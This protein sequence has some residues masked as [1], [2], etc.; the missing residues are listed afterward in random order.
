MA[1]TAALR[2]PLRR[3][4][5][6]F[7]HRRPWLKLSL[8]LGPPM[9]WMLLVYLGA[10]LILFLAAFWRQDPVTSVVQREWGAQNFRTLV[11]REIYRIIT[12]R[13][14]GI[15]L[16]ATLADILLALPLAYYAARL[17]TPKIRTAI[18]LSITLPLW[19]SYL[20]RVYAWRVILAD[21]GA[22]D[23]TLSKLQ[24]GALH[25]GFS[26]WSVWIVFV[27]LWL[28]YVMLPIYASLE[29]IPN[30]FVEASADLG[31]RWWIT[32][33]RVI[34]PIAL[35]GIVAGSI[36]SFSLTLGDYIAPTLVGNT[37]FIGNVVYQAQGVANNV[38]FAAAF[39]I[40]PVVIMAFYLLAARRLGAFEAL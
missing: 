19:S 11:E 12:L 26:N 21:N 25:L 29:R 1:T 38:P 7:V 15:A 32:L 34:V 30:S 14:A 5:A 18:L 33:R 22:L 39:A 16:A 13:T 2:P 28:P 8:L 4:L 10:L 31:A 37:Q 3:R 40:V 9:G 27:Y 36:F 20:V 24:L 17:A 6:S 35:P 23:W